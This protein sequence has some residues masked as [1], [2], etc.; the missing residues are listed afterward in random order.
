MYDGLKDERKTWSLG[1]SV[2]G[3]YGLKYSTGID[4]RA[5]LHK[6][7]VHLP[8]FGALIASDFVSCNSLGL[9]EERGSQ[10]DPLILV[11]VVGP[12]RWWFNH[13]PKATMVFRIQCMSNTSGV[14]G[15]VE[16]IY[17]ELPERVG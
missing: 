14:R 8:H 1:L 9:N 12:I 4:H 17:I 15:W 6:R 11:R 7:A 2:C 16:G 5:R 3:M 10:S 13:Q